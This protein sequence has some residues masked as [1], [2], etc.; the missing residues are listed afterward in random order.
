MGRKD[1][2]FNTHTMDIANKTETDLLDMTK[3]E[4]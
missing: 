2:L 1:K 3:G 4:Q